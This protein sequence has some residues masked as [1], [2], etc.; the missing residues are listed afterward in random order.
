MYTLHESLHVL[1]HPSLLT[2]PGHGNGQC[3]DGH[4]GPYCG[5]CKPGWAL[6]AGNKCV[7]CSASGAL[8][9]LSNPLFI[10]T[11]SAWGMIG[12]AW[13]MGMALLSIFCIRARRRGQRI[14]LRVP[15]WLRQF[16]DRV[17]SKVKVLI[18][19]FQVCCRDVLLET[20]GGGN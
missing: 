14:K 16:K 4:T 15:N 5:L 11:L 20:S 18:S 2:Q 3:V 19:F 7:E 1:V 9:S 13:L 6:G 8:N 10:V 17:V 12:A